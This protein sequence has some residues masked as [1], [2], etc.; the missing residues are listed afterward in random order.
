[1]YVFIDQFENYVALLFLF[2]MDHNS[3]VWAQKWHENK[4]YFK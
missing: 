2:K 4:W 3:G 1:M